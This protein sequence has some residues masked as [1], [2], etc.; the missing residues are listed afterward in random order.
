MMDSEGMKRV[1][2]VTLM[3]LMY[4]SC[5]GDVDSPVASG[6]GEEGVPVSFDRNVTR[7]SGE[8]TTTGNISGMAVFGYVTAGDWTEAATPDFMYGQKVTK[9]GGAWT[10]SPAKYWPSAASGN[11]VS[12]FAVN[13]VPSTANGISVVKTQS[14]AGYPVFA[15][16]P[17]DSPSSQV[18]FCVASVMNATVEDVNGDAQGFP[19][20]DVPFTF[21]HV[22]TQVNFSARYT[23]SMFSGEVKIKDLILSGIKN[24]GTLAFTGSGYEW[25]STAATTGQYYL[26]AD[27]GELSTTALTT[28]WARISTARG[29]LCLVPQ[30]VS[31]SIPFTASFNGAEYVIKDTS[32]P[33][34]TWKAGGSY[35]YSVDVDADKYGLIAES[36]TKWD[37]SYTGNQQT[38][39]A[40]ADG[41]YK[42]EAWGA[43]GGSNYNSTYKGS[44]GYTKGV[45]YL[46]K[47]QKLYVYVG[48]Y[49]NTKSGTATFNGGG[50][51]LANT[52]SGLGG[53]ATDFRLVPGDANTQW[54][55]PVSLN[56]RIMVAGGG[57]GSG[58]V[59]TN[60]GQQGHAGGLEGWYCIKPDGGGT[61]TRGGVSGSYQNGTFGKGGSTNT[62]NYTSG[63]GGGYYGGASDGYTYGAGSGGSSFISGMTGCVAIDPTDTT[64][65]PRT[66]DSGVGIL[67]RATLNYSNTAF[68]ASLTWEDG[69]DILFTNCSMVD[70]GGY[71]W[72]TGVKAGAA[73]TMPNPSGGTMTGNENS[74]GYARITQLK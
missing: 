72:N 4:V 14:E 10:Y 35:E 15:V 46:K 27:D 49:D 64:N 36:T 7:V 5:T 44:G 38:F 8:L 66:Q 60:G 21:D 22:M 68:G 54:D 16:S 13:P 74:H 50:S 17:P 12:F 6:S 20:G 51:V 41:Y 30:T 58:D 37:F 53:G 9:S 43:S 61:Q 69:E 34:V 24:S 26:T 57:A 39:T 40:P 45:I 56:S 48:Q 71:E 32:F 55:K 25:T 73:G 42:L 18:D 29:T 52:N 63:G 65:D 2:T 31:V 19:T 47:D 28:D 3:A 62:G 1:M 33:A 11:K 67:S 23:A 59:S 70:G